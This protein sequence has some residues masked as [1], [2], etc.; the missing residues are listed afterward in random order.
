MPLRR[1]RRAAIA[2][3]TA[4]ALPALLLSAAMGIEVARWSDV[5]LQLQ[6]KADLA[7]LAGAEAYGAGASAQAAANAAAN[8]AEFNAAGGGGTRSWTASSETLSDNQISVQITKGVNNPA[9]PAV[10]VTV[11]QTIPL[12]FAAIISGVH[13]ITMAATAMSEV[14]TTINGAQPCILTLNGDV[15]GVVALPGTTLSGNVN[16]NLNGCSMVSDAN[17]GMS[18][19]LTLNTVGIYS[20]GTITVSGHVS[21][22]AT[23]TAAQHPGAAQVPN[24]YVNDTAL[25]NAIAQAQCGPTTQPTSSKGVTTLYPNV[26][27]GSISISGSTTLVFSGTGLYTVNGSLSVSGNTSVGGTYISGSGITLVSSG[28][29]SISGNFNT[30]AITLT[31]PSSGTSAGGALAGVLFATNSNAGVT[32]SGNS[33]IPFTGL[34]Y[35]PNSAISLSGNATDGS[36]GCAEVIAN[37]LTI[38]GNVNLAANCSNYSLLNF[39]SQPNTTSIGLVQ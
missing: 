18:G 30:G 13:P 16:A 9:D 39:G 34:I 24:P 4:L 8:V 36:T 11:T 1:D 15:N 2:L 33:A 19:N 28:G 6:R 12:L 10:L 21:G 26:C 7:A 17:T 3:I 31:A 32:I 25:Q 29:I 37:T 22:T 27:Y 14:G 20:A 38:S 5:R 35:A 23:N